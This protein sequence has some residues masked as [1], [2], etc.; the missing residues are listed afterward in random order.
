MPQPEPMD[1]VFLWVN[2]SGEYFQDTMQERSAGEYV[3]SRGRGKRYRDNGEVRGAIRSAIKSLGDRLGTVHVLSG[4]YEINQTLH[5]DVV[6]A[7][8]SA[9][10][11]HMGQIPHWLNWNSAKEGLHKVAWHFHSS[12]WRLP[13]DNKADEPLTPDQAATEE[14]W[15]QHS[16]P[17]FNSFAI[18][19]RIGWINGLSETFLLANDDMFFLNSLNHADFQHPLLGT[20]LRMD[21]GPGLR[22]KPV[23]TPDL[24]SSP[25]EW[26][27][28][29]HAAMLIK[30][31]FTDQKRMYMAHMPKALTL[32]LTHEASVMFGVELSEAATR[33]F[34]QSQR[35]VADV[36]MSW[37]VSHLRIE[38]WREGLL[39]TWVVARLGG[40]DGIWGKQA[41][42]EMSELLGI[43]SSEIDEVIIEKGPRETLAD[44]EQINKNAGWDSTEFTKYYY[45][46]FDGTV[47]QNLPERPDRPRTQTECTFRVAQCLP[48]DFFE[49]DEPLDAAEMFRHFTF[50]EPSCG[51]CLIMALVSASGPRGLEAFFPDPDAVFHPPAQ[52]EPAAFQREEPMLPLTPSWVDTDFRI[53]SIMRSGQDSWPGVKPRMDGSVNMRQWC[54]KLLS[55]YAY[56]FAW[57]Q[58]QFF[59]I[60]S[61]IQLRTAVN[62]LDSSPRMAMTCI[63]DDQPDIGSVGVSDVFGRWMESRWGDV[64]AGWEEKNVPWAGSAPK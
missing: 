56:V 19:S 1:V 60:H 18:E 29:Q 48:P 51:D 50:S 11:W 31:R 2:A 41:K 37:L 35:G 3:G 26:G 43:N 36:E 44:L 30:N 6:P 52:Q 5:P 59:Q 64:E 34:R 23:V 53:E 13:A 39:W 61:T 21:P 25:G 54:I 8:A 14:A 15:R 10:S 24:K 9:P 40:Q 63:N 16:L 12:I 45:S 57:T 32:S 4:D 7:G 62:K 27:G 33:G 47:P 46:S 38:R 49:S 58:T 42:A 20:V 28:L 22:V 55:R 17:N